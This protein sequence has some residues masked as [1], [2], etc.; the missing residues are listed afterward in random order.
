MQ[1][2]QYV[3]HLCSKYMLPEAEEMSDHQEPGF[4]CTD[5]FDFD[6]CLSSGAVASHGSTRT[7]GVETDMH[8]A[9]VIA[10][11]KIPRL[12]LTVKRDLPGEERADE[13]GESSSGNAHDVVLQWQGEGRGK[14]PRTGSAAHEDTQEAEET[15]VDS[16]RK[17]ADDMQNNAEASSA[18]DA[19]ED[20][21]VRLHVIKYGKEKK[22]ATRVRVNKVDLSAH[23]GLLA[24]PEALRGL[25]AMRELT[26]ASTRL[27]MLPEWLGELRGLEVLCVQGLDFNNGFPLEALQVSLGVMTELKTLDLTYCLALT[28]LPESLG[29][30][31]GPR[32]EPV[33]PCAWIGLPCPPALPP[34]SPHLSTH[35]GQLALPEALRGLT[36][37]Q[38]L[39]VASTALRML[40]EWLGEL[41]GLEVLHVQGVAIEAGYP[42][43]ALLASLRALTGLKRLILLCCSMLTALLASLRALTGLE[44]LDLARCTQLKEV[45]TWVMGLYK[46][47]VPF[48]EVCLCVIGASGSDSG[49]MEVVTHVRV[50]KVDLLAHT[51]L[52]T[53]PEALRGLTA[54][55][56][57]WVASIELETLT[58]WLG[59]LRG[60]KVLRVGG[61][62]KHP[63]PLQ[64]LPA[65]L[66]VLTGL[67]T[68]DLRYCNAVTALLAS[69]G[70]IIRLWTMNLE[71]CRAL[72]ALPESLG[73]LTGLSTLDLGYCQKLSALPALIGDLKGLTMLILGSCTSL[74]VLP[75]SFGVLTGLTA[76][77]ASLGVLMGLTTLDLRFCTA[78]TAVP[79]S[80][81]ALTGLTTLNLLGCK[82][83]TA[84]PESIGVLMGLETLNLK[85]C[86]ALTALPVSLGAL[87]GLT[88]LDMFCCDTLHALPW[89]IVH[90]GKGAVLQFLRDL[91][92]GEAPSHLIK[93]VLLG[94]QRAGKNSLTDWLV[95]RR[96]ATRADNDQTVGIEVWR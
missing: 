34:L 10:S 56:E 70:E 2:W 81:G 65:S 31:T 78:L 45:P 75:M 79:E 93:V 5:D 21:E 59:K 73:A 92:K 38:E 94:D 86:S 39:T 49:E 64:A 32:A 15:S 54:M 23:T 33:A 18:A 35:T 29:A 58:E 80:L 48:M 47:K 7:K 4:E 28:A 53:L 83:L 24:L 1:L 87:T 68:L 66:G 55:R 8:V 27:K 14:R 12:A 30:L 17:C 82:A 26:V 40:P 72:T 41:R 19:L 42:L 85:E 95:L 96:P 63:C 61:N 3:R 9:P 36:A 6:M 16:S 90:A 76:L 71:N 37:M 25:T 22:V 60:L 11:N 74:T 20:V 84:L 51:R 69:L 62:S 52:M 44:H 77:P 50:D 13:D 46:L 43:E 88:T 57:L 89:S 67:T 91:A